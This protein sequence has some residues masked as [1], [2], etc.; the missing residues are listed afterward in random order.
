MANGFGWFAKGL[1]A[2]RK[3]RICEIRE[4]F[5]NWLILPDTF[6]AP[7]RKRL[8]FPLTDVLAFLVASPFG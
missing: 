7:K 6:G 4:F 8:F 2:I 5:S 1:R 3:H